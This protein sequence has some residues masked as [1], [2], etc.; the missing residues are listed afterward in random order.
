M[1]EMRKLYPVSFTMGHV[2]FSRG[3]HN[4]IIRNSLRVPVLG[5]SIG[6]D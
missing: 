5:A 4:G 1:K 2:K 3:A 6:L